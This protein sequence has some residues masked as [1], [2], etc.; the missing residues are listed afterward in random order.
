MSVKKNIKYSSKPCLTATK[1]S[2]LWMCHGAFNHSSLAG[3]V[4][5]WSHFSCVWLFVT[6]WTIA[7][8]ALCPWDSPGKNTGVGCRALLQGIFLTQGSNLHLLCLLPAGRLFTTS[9]TWE[10]LHWNHCKA[11]ALFDDPRVP[12]L[13]PW[14]FC[15]EGPWL[16][17]P[18]HRK[19]QVICRL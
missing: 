18:V 10:I 1:D 13:T 11:L 8:Q 2:H 3:H 4:C 17:G 19:I 5:L 16:P 9:T 12:L 15:R 14:R 6:P 7:C